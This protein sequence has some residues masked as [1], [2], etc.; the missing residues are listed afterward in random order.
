MKSYFCASSSFSFLI[1]DLRSQPLLDG[2]HI[3]RLAA[4]QD[5]VGVG[6]GTLGGHPDTDPISPNL[7]P[8]DGK[9]AVAVEANLVAVH[10]VSE[11]ARHHKAEE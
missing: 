2:L 10:G 3:D 11:E 4:D 7:I 8:L 9:L 6:L 1:V 5:H